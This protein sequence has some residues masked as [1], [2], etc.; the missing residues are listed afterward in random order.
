M[1]ICLSISMRHS[2]KDIYFCKRGCA[3]VSAFAF[4]IFCNLG[5]R[6]LVFYVDGMIYLGD[7]WCLE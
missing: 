1:Y 3:R 2:E 7:G 4:I 6:Y 5:K